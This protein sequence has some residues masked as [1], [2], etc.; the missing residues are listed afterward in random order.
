MITVMAW[1]LIVGGVLF[2][3]TKPLTWSQLSLERNLWNVFSKTLSVVCG[4][5]LLKMRKWAVVLYF[6]AF[7][8]NTALLFLWPPNAEVLERYSKPPAIA[9]MLVIPVIIALITLPKWNLM[10]WGHRS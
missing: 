8:L 9:M 7:A 6:A 3:M 5:G 2:L 1:I 10:T 4:V